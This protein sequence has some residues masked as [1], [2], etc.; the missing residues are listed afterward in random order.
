MGDLFAE[1]IDAFGARESAVPI[2]IGRTAAGLLV[3]EAGAEGMHFGDDD[4]EERRHRNRPAGART[5]QTAKAAQTGKAAQ[6]AK[7]AQTGKAAQTAKVAR[8]KAGAARQKARAARQ[9]AG[10]AQKSRAA[11]THGES[12]NGEAV[13]TWRG[14]T[15]TRQKRMQ[16]ARSRM[17]ASTGG[18]GEA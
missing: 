12:S 10:A 7:A 3:A 1:G 11:A 15:R 2:A 18:H 8:Q 6:T 5:A 16:R 4:V 13:G 9:K 14:S 17:V